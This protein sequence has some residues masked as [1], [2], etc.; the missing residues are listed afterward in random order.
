MKFTPKTEEQIIKEQMPPEGW[1]ECEVVKAEDTSSK[2][3]NP[4]MKLHLRIFTDG[5]ERTM[6]DYLLESFAMKLIHFCRAAGLEDRYASGELEAKDC[7]G[8]TVECEITHKVQKTGE[9]A[10]Q[11]QANI[12]DYR[13]VQR[14]KRAS[15]PS[16]SLDKAETIKESDIPF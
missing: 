7:V 14:T 12:A 2:A 15:P 1:W 8:C 6:F 9:Y 13:A 11:T 5:G 10:G 4:M 16:R 3:G